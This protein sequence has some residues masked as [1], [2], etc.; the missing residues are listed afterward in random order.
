VSPPEAEGCDAIQDLLGAYALDALDLDEA[1]LVEKHLETC[2]RCRQ[3]VDQH[4]ETAGLLAS[5][6]GTAPEP[7]WERIA[8][9]I[10]R[11]A[12]SDAPPVPR[13]VAPAA[14]PRRWRRAA[15][16]VAV[17][18]AAAL[19]VLVGVGT[20]RI[21]DLNHQVHQLKIANGG[22]AAA[23][24][25]PSAHHLTLATTATGQTIGELVVL[26]TGESYLVWSALPNV[27]SVHTY[28]LWS[29]L[30][31]RFVSVSLLGDHPA[32]VAFR[33]DPAPTPQAFLITV[34]PAGGVVAPT[35][36]PVAKATD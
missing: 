17:A 35:S 25:N 6:G 19:L 14:R 18:A 27:G 15:E 33:V 11:P 13:L 8:G 22:V 1:A 20:V 10:E 3:E 16:A 5:A 26:P 32:T 7:V 31:G 4:R 21:N 34:E 24:L 2:P 12:P 28:Q 9:A 29:M 36:S 23:L 30:N